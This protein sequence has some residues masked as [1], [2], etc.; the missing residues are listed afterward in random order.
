MSG[1]G[2]Q[3]FDS[4]V[5]AQ[6]PATS[7]VGNITEIHA[8]SKCEIIDFLCK[9][10]SVDILIEIRDILFIDVSSKFEHYHGKELISRRRLSTLAKDIFLMGQSI[11]NN[12]EEKELKTAVKIDSEPR[13]SIT[14]VN[15]DED[16]SDNIEIMSEI[17]NMMSKILVITTSLEKRMTTMENE[18]SCVKV[19]IVQRHNS[20]IVP[21]SLTLAN[22]TLPAP[23]VLDDNQA[24]DTQNIDDTIIV[25]I[26]QTQDSSD[27]RFVDDGA[28]LTH[29]R[30]PQD[31]D[32]DPVRSFDDGGAPLT[33]PRVPQDADHDLVRSLVESGALLTLPRTLQDGERDLVRNLIDGGAQLTLPWATRAT[34]ENMIKN[35]IIPQGQTS[36]LIGFRHPKQTRPPRETNTCNTPAV[37]VHNRF[38]ALQTSPPAPEKT[39]T[40]QFVIEAAKYTQVTRIFV[41]SLAPHTRQAKIRQ[42]L[43]NIGTPAD[44]IEDVSNINTKNTSMA[45]FCITISTKAAAE[46]VLNKNNWPDGTNVAIFQSRK[47]HPKQKGSWGAQTK[48]GDQKGNWVRPNSK[49]NQSA[50]KHNG[51]SNQHSQVRY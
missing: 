11:V 19:A 7:Y 35:R 37:P 30:V 12:I 8:N 41:G 9:K 3:V 45:A 42:H 34:D 16:G 43:V 50:N 15:G 33:H 47:P 17:H 4:I 40:G 27:P 46:G 48:R 10:L 25:S 38:A 21:D 20:G 2:V 26:T 32:R 6:H 22:K 23:G 24:F 51:R 18:L 28:Q 39:K 49:N 31:A 14:A 36:P 5:E 1:H 29:P 13:A 44:D